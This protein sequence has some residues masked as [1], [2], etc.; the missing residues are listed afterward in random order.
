VHSKK[1]LPKKGE[2]ELTRLTKERFNEC[3][4]ELRDRYIYWLQGQGT[5]AEVGEASRRAIEYRLA[6]KDPAANRIKL[7]HEQADFARKV[8]AQAG[9]LFKRGGTTKHIIDRNYAKV[10]RLDAEV[11]YVRAKQNEKDPSK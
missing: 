11:Q 3:Q 10:F 1:L 2:D 9:E 6:V 8:E 4:K 5:L 7:L